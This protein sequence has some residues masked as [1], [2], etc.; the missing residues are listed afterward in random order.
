MSLH[1]IPGS[2]ATF[3]RILA[4]FP[5]NLSLAFAYGSAVYRQAGPNGGRKNIMLDFVFSVD[6]PVTWHSKNLQ[7]NRNHYSCLRLFGPN[8]IAKVQN[9]FGAGIYYN[10]MIKCDGKLIKY[11]VIS[12]DTLIKDL[13]TWDT[14]YVA[15][16]LQKP[17]QLLVKHGED[18]I[19]KTNKP[20]TER[21]PHTGS[22]HQ[23]FPPHLVE[24]KEEIFQPALQLPLGP[25]SLGLTNLS[26]GRLPVCVV[27]DCRSAI[28][29]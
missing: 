21:R 10:A 18:E 24:E 2:M 14:L 9:N 17:V 7:K 19:K 25:V 13:L 23:G 28:G 5:D 27:W 8:V 1:T 16:R 4:N 20:L 11:G 29:D 15:G 12:T 6:D 26:F 3:R 22:E